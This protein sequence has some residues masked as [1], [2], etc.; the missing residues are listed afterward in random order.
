MVNYIMALVKFMN[1]HLLDSYQFF[2]VHLKKGNTMVL[3]IV[4][5]LVNFSLRVP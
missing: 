1:L 5:R 4:T 2:M 3:L